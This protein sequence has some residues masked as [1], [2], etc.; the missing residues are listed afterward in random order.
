MKTVETTDKPHAAV[1]SGKGVKVERAITISRPV[2]EVYAFWRHFENL[3]RFMN[4]VNS[5]M[6]RDATHSHWTVRTP[7]GKLVEW[8]AELIEERPNELLSWRSLPGADV[9][10]AGSVWFTPAPGNRGTV[11]KVSLKYDPP[12][13]KLGVAIAK[14]FGQDAEA[15]IQDDL[16]RLKSLLETGEMPTIHG[17]PSGMEGG[18]A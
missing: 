14:M 17:Q 2:S 3:S 13:T 5:V 9:D 1:A 16:Y 18:R 4:H 10:N 6:E 7:R 8:D 11:L 15:E 12:A